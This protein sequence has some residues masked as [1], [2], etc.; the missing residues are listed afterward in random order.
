MYK[1]LIILLLGTNIFLQAQEN[2]PIIINDSIPATDYY[3]IA[4]QPTKATFYSAIL[5]GMGQAYNKDYW[6]IPVV[7]VALGTGVYFYK[8]NNDKFHEYR[9]AYKLMKMGQ[10]TQYDYLSVSVL[11][12]AQTYHKKY[13]DLSTMITALMYVMQVVEASVDAHLQYHNT[14]PELTFQPVIIPFDITDNK[15][16]GISVQYRF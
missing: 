14:D 6:K 7:Y 2:E 8:F 4:I 11:E 12:R 5:P 9:D 13:R 15:T 10:P 3:Q 1:L 16:F